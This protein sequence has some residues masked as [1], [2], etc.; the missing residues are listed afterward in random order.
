MKYILGILIILFASYTDIFLYRV[1]VIPVTPSSF[2]I[3]LFFALFV[4]KYNIKDILTRFK[5]HTFKFFFFILVLS[6]LYS[7]FAKAPSD[8][9]ITIISLDV[10]N[11]ILYVFILHFF[12]VEDKQ[13]IFIVIFVAFIIL[14]GSVWYDFI[15]GLPKNNLTLEQMVRKGG[16]GENPNKAA[17]GI[18]FLALG[19][20]FFLENVKTKKY[21]FVALMVISVFVTF[22]RSGTVSV[23]LILLLGTINNWSSSFQI[24]LPKLIKNGFRLIILFSILYLTLLVLAGVIKENFPAFTR[25][26]AGERMDLLLGQS[27]KSAIA[28][29][30]GSGGGRGDL[31]FKYI[32]T[33]VSN[34][35]GS[36][37]GFSSDKNF[38]HL[39]THN[40]YLYFAVNYGIFGLLAFLFFI[41]Y[42]INFSINMNQFYTFIFFFIFVFEGLIAHDIFSERAILVSLAFF[43]SLLYRKLKY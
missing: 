8:V 38:N 37:T 39:N 34:P 19:V 14:A 12:C 10:I 3:P 28:E 5:S 21:L 4:I 42:S 41:G 18:K 31:F 13:T 35:L 17:S 24:D 9:L 27:E 22:S 15:F 7:S 33:F 1:N 25:G 20:L 29:D 43:D 30:T 36:G 6:V 40:Q 23:I 11:I 2:L 16:F 26:A 32:D